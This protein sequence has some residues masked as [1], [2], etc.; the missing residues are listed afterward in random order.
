MK[1]NIFSL[2]F[3]AVFFSGSAQEQ[4]PAIGTIEFLSDELNSLIKKD[5]KV[6][7]VSEGFSLPG[8]NK[9]DKSGRVTLLIDSIEQPNGIGI[10]P[11]GKTLIVSNSDDRKKRWYLYDITSNASLA[12]GRVFY[13]VSNEKGMG[14]CDGL[15]IDKSGNVFA[16]GPGGIW[17]FTKAG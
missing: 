8:S 7:I 4:K 2:L 13:D 6:E 5:A 14:G 17:I 12:N 1:K 11:D 10:F 16:A 15:K 9:M 3:F